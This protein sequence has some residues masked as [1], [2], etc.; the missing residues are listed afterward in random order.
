MS[1]PTDGRAPLALSYPRLNR[2][3]ANPA[4]AVLA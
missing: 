4:G 3:G 2:L 1:Q